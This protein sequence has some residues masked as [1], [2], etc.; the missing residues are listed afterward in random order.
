MSIQILGG[1]GFIGTHLK[2]YLEP[3]DVRVLSLRTANWCN[4]IDSHEGCIVNLVGKAHD[5]TGTATK[6]DYYFANLELV[7]QIFHAFVSSPAHLLIHISSLA[8]L[9]EFESDHPLT[10]DDACHPISWYGKSKRAAEEWLM[11]Q[12]VPVGKKLII[13]RPPMVHGPG[14]KGNLGLLYKFVS[15][16]IPYPLAAFDNRRSFISIDNFCYFI[17]KIIDESDKLPGGIFHIA[18]DES[19]STREIIAIIKQ[20]THKKAINV[21]IPRFLVRG[22]AKVGDLIP[23]PLNT[24]R[25]KKLTANLLVSNLHIKSSLSIDA[26]PLSARDGMIK[27]IKAFRD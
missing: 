22:L 14:D 17:K 2:T 5:H 6:S 21:A 27:T 16:G 15:K 11:S 25:L 12:E 1:N 7:K 26:L 9:E 4:F 10:E 19:I 3:V 8:A 23:L 18:D 13:V 24:K 20:I